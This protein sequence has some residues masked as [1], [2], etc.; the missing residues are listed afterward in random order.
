M[1]GEK[2]TYVSM[3]RCLALVILFLVNIESNAQTPV[4]SDEK[5]TP[6]AAQE[7]RAPVSTSP[8]VPVVPATT[9]ADATKPADAVTSDATLKKAKSEETPKAA[10]SGAAPPQGTCKRTITADVVALAQPYMLNRLGASV[11]GGLIFALRSDTVPE[12]IRFG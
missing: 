11:P 2:S 8:A 1:L 3:V 9:E 12:A 7:Q 6:P 5:T 4:V 10:S